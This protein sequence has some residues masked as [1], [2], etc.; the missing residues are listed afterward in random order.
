MKM[1]ERIPC[2]TCNGTGR[3]VTGYGVVCMELVERLEKCPDCG[4]EGHS[5]K[6]DPS[7]IGKTS[8]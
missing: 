8:P 1:S 7:N 2:P 4:G 3:V 5:K 6:Y